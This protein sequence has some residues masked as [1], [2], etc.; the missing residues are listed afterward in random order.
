MKLKNTTFELRFIG[1]IVTGLLF[2]FTAK[3]QKAQDSLQTLKTIPIQEVI[4]TGTRNETDVRNL[5][6][7]IS[8]VTDKQL[9]ERQIQSIL[10]I[11]NEQVPGLFITSRGIMGYG[12]S[13]GA[14][15]AMR[16]RGVG[17]SPTAGLLVLIDGE[18]QYMGLMGHPLAD[19]YQTTMADRVEVVRGPASVLYGSNA[20]GGVINIVTS[21][22]KKDTVQNNA[23]FSYGTYNTLESSFSNRIQKGRFN[24]KAAVSYNRT[25]GQ[26][27][28]MEFDQLSGNAKLGYDLSKAWNVNANLALTHFNASNPGTIANPVIDNDSRITRGTTIF[29]LENNYSQTSG[30]VKFYYNWGK[31]IIND[32]YSAGKQPLDYRFHSNDRMSGLSWYQSVTVLPGNRITAGVDYQHFGGKAWNKYTNDSEKAIVDTTLNEIAGYVDVRQA[33]GSFFTLDAGIRYDYHSQTGSQ[34]IPQFGLSAHLPKTI[35]VKAMVSK[36]FRNPTIRELFMFPPKNANLLPEKLMNYELSLSQ[37]LFHNKLNYNLNLF[38]IDGENMIQMIFSQGKPL[39]VNTGLIQNHGA[40]V[41]VNFRI[42]QHWAAN[43]NYSWLYMKYPVIAA[44]QHKAFAGIDYSNKKLKASTGLQYINGLYTSV[45]P[46]S[47]ENFLL[48]NL[49]GNYQLAKSVGCF[50]SGENLLGQSYEINAGYPMPKATF[51]TGINVQF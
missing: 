13:T 35:E 18:P 5:P 26:R 36:G 40:E 47:S 15:G 23:R 19:M 24:S 30:A 14:A 45:T 12:V 41:V 33:L 2:S 9:N 34:W 11:L 17:G 37:S 4:V 32:G 16:L 38:Y 20:M 22:L 46:V 39:N 1:L 7:S 42:N 29:S 51:S 44:P 49:R 31:H 43:A 28:N 48:W 10:P 8:V 50:V 6:V 27:E 25:D 3:A 21:K